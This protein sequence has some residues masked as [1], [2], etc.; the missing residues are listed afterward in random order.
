MT[1]DN[2]AT[3]ALATDL[4][5]EIEAILKAWK[6]PNLGTVVFD[7]DAADLVID[8]QERTNKG[9]GYRAITYAAFAIG[10][11]RYCRKK[12]IPHPGIV[13]LDTPVNPFK[14]PDTGIDAE[15]VTDVVKEAFYDN[16][17]ADDSGDQIIIME[18]E[19]LPSRLK[20]TINYLHFSKHPTIGRYG[21]FPPNLCCAVSSVQVVYKIS[22]TPG[23]SQKSLGGSSLQKVVETQSVW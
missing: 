4:C 6:Y 15:K 11:M 18:N 5:K 14:D 12:N 3:T 22:N 16:L 20:S 9:K 10:L 17:A 2:R 7:T 23:F 1:F 21:F 19:E 13:I 8:E